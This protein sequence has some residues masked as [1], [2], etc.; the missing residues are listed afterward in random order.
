M[1]RKGISVCFILDHKLM[2]YRIPFFIQLFERGFDITIV[3]PGDPVV[4]DFP[5]KQRTAIVKKIGPL[6]YRTLDDLSVFHIVI[7]MQNL[8]I[9][10]LWIK[11]LNPFKRYKLIHWGIG[12]SSSKGLSSKRTII[13]CIRGFLAAR[14]D[15]QVLYTDFPL[16]LFSDKVRKKT[17]I[18]NNTVYNPN[19]T[20]Y[21][22]FEKST[23]LFIGSLNERKGLDLL[24]NTFHKYLQ[25]NKSSK[26]DTLIIIGDG[27]SKIKLLKLVENLGLGKTVIFPGN[28]SD[29]E[30][31]KQYF[32]D[33]VCCISPRQAG[34]SVLESFSYGV[35]FITYS[36]AI[37]GGE[38]FNI[39]NNVNGYL[40]NSPEE[41]FER[42]EYLG[43]NPRAAY[44]LG[45]NA[46][47]H[48]NNNRKMSDMVDSFVNAFNFV[49]K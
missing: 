30:I 22:D 33:A 8:R 10:N 23:F 32:I 43:N 18:A 3:H 35:P 14:A 36:D 29:P 1:K 49:L 24:I 48:Y 19:P 6:E 5:F 37:S 21:S 7:F 44:I 31:K 41:L 26:I 27:P 28:I 38:H 15:A 13:S 25:N 9:I 11:T 45:K 42:M 40:V 46:F 17:F 2:I 47:S 4:G 34:L 20:D 39:Q 16:K 12:G